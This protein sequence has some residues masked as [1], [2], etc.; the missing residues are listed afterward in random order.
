MP[1]ALPSLAVT[2]LKCAA[3]AG[4]AYTAGRRQARPQPAERAAAL[5]VV[6]EGVTVGYGREGTGVRL[7]VAAAKRHILSLTPRARFALDAR[8]IARVRLRTTA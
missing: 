6:E 4:V 7:D 2:A 3:L 8:L 1:I 5:D